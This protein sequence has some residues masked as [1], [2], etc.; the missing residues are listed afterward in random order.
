M[1]VK[2]KKHEIVRNKEKRSVEREGG[3]GEKGR[4]WDRMKCEYV[5]VQLLTLVPFSR[6][7]GRAVRKERFIS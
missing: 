7:M 5:C 1:H 4:G 2:E 6:R 3:M